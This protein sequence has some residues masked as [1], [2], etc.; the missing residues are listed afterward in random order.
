MSP[1][2]AT[3]SGCPFLFVYTLEEVSMKKFTI[4]FLSMLAVILASP[5]LP[6]ES[7]AEISKRNREKLLEGT[8]VSKLSYDDAYD[9]AL[10]ENKTLVI[11]VN[12]ERPREEAKLKDCVHCHVKRYKDSYN[13]GVVIGKFFNGKP[14]RDDLL[15]EN[16]FALDIVRVIEKL[17]KLVSKP[18]E[19]DN[20][21]PQN[22][23]PR[24]IQYY[25]PPGGNFAPQNFQFY[26]QWNF[27]PQNSFQ[28]NF[29]PQNYRSS[30]RSSGSC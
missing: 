12:L 19:A 1:E 30:G 27:A 29:A 18:K 8:R 14:V 4:V 11:W 28:S 16:A 24:P 7:I 5:K 6:G 2:W 10:A 9:K 25:T 21:A 26:P 15:A 13:P 17:E 23:N 3:L 20:F 22:T